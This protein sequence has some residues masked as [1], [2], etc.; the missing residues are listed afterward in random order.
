MESSKQI[1]AS[2]S[3][4]L[5][6]R[7][8]GL[9]SEQEQRELADWLEADTANRVAFLRLEAGWERIA[10]LKALAAGAK[11]GIPPRRGRWGTSPFFRKRSD[12]AA[13]PLVRV[14]RPRLVALAASVLL[15]VAAGVYFN[16]SN[17]DGRYTTVIG[18]VSSIPLSDGST[19]TLN[20][21]SKV[22]VALTQTQRY[23]ALDAGEAFFEVAKDASRPFVVDI[24]GKRVVAVGTQF[25]VRRYG[26]D[27]QVVV[28]EGKVRLEQKDGSAI[29]E[30]LTAGEVAHTANAAVLVQR[31]SVREAEDALSWRRGY[32]IFD[33][34]LLVDAVT[35][36]NRYTS[37]KIQ[38]EGPKLAS[39]RI[40]GKFRATN[41]D[42][43]IHVLRNGFGV[44]VR[45]T[46]EGDVRAKD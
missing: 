25:S 24:G 16:S 35:E 8:T 39:L 12:A 27:L 37:R 28:T 9:L 1:E 34:T 44:Q 32:L 46:V 43:F 6:K 19:M 30:L 31:R 45:E 29:S 36:F 18:G 17:S 4:W 23:I 10:R 41:A 14:S 3:A 26:E 5:A 2:A 7:D 33:E 21:A 42:D 15:A 22:R 20:T 11:P 38:V 40:S 13:R